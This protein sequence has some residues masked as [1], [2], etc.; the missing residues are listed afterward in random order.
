MKKELNIEQ[1]HE[2]VQKEE[3]LYLATS[4]NDKVTMRIVSP[5]L[6]DDKI[7]FYTGSHSNKYKQMEVNS[8]VAGQ[9]GNYQFEGVVTFLGYFDLPENERIK[10]LYKEKYV[11]AFEHF[12]PGEIKE[13]IEFVE[14]SL[15]HVKAFIFEG[16]FPREEESFYEI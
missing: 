13:N 3:M 15:A 11:G 2:V 4:A 12:M 5:L 10:N 14:I 9:I 1:F 7:I 6:V 8:N 16:E